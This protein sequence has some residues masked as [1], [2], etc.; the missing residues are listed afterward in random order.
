LL[1]GTLVSVFIERKLK[2]TG[3]FD[4]L[5]LKT[6]LPPGV[7]LVCQRPTIDDDGWPTPPTPA[8]YINNEC[9]Y[10]FLNLS[11]ISQMVIFSPAANSTLSVA[12]EPLGP[13]WYAHLLNDSP[14]GYLC[15]LEGKIPT[16]DGTSCH[17]KVC[18]HVTQI[19]NSGLNGVLHCT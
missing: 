14:A 4:G 12:P 17:K 8:F 16:C 19:S 18:Q 1:A 15:R 9:R 3:R 5:H 11:G 13:V 7:L 2:L 10:L 6:S